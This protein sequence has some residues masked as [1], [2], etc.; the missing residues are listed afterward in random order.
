MRELDLL[1]RDPPP[2]V[3]VWP[4]RTSDGT[5]SV[6]A[7][8]ARLQGP[9]ESPFE[10]GTFALRVTVPMR[11]PH[12]PP[13]VQ[14]VTRVYHPNVDSGGRICLDSLKMPPS[15]AW[16]PSLNIGQVL[17]QIRL[18]LAEPNP[19]DP[20]MPE[21]SEQFRSDPKRFAKIAKDYT[22]RYAVQNDAQN[23]VQN[24]D[25][26]EN[27]GA[28]NENIEKDDTTAGRKRRDGNTEDAA[29]TITAISSDSKDAEKKN[30][31]SKNNNI[32]S[33]NVSGDPTQGIDERN[34]DNSEIDNNVV[35]DQKAEKRKSSLVLVGEHA[36]N[37]ANQNDTNTEDKEK[38]SQCVD[39]GTKK[40]KSNENGNSDDD[41]VIVIE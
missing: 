24:D 41:D 20:L 14:F 19:D 8:E 29:N 28:G 39:I 37:Q 22:R 6:D 4:T 15:G 27:K 1:A 11:Y 40:H 5:D 10:G 25:Y 2:G 36:S 30:D 13:A 21:I 12:E 26:D 31:D 32:V 23:E 34:K 35:Q 33:K 18:L 7:L 3:A 16:K 17:S 38:L 9:P